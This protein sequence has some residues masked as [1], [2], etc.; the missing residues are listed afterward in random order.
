MIELL[1]L[2]IAPQHLLYSIL[3]LLVLVYWITVFLG[4]L[5]LHFLDAHHDAD[6]HPDAHDGTDAHAHG[7]EAGGLLSEALGFF[8]FGQVP[9]MVFATFLVLFLWTGSLLADVLLGGSIWFF[10]I[11]LLPN[12]LIAL[13]FT[14]VFTEPFKR[15]FARMNA[16]GKTKR[17]LVGKIGQVVTRIA[18]GRLGSIDIQTDDGHFLLNAV[19]HQDQPIEKGTQAL[20]VE[21]DPERDH[22]VVE[23]FDAFP[24][25]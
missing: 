21:F 18:P 1:R 8:N 11:W 17:E 16:G 13:L 12:L 20:I 5:D 2:A 4:A 15:V 6:V 25:R 19:T 3:L 7:G 9:F 22:Y 10:L 23:P 14:K 24:A